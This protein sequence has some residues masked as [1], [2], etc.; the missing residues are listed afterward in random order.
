MSCD[1]VHYFNPQCVPLGGYVLLVGTQF[2]ECFI[3]SLNCQP[4]IFV[5]LSLVHLDIISPPTC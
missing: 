3:F 2:S 1:L 4:A 5:Y